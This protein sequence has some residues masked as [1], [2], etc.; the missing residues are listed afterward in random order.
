MFLSLGRPAMAALMLLFASTSVAA[1]TPLLAA[2]MF[3]CTASHSGSCKTTG[4]PVRLMNAEQPVVAHVTWKYRTGN[5][6]RSSPVV[7]NDVLFVGS[8]NGTFHAIDA[9]TGKAK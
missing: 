1:P 4:L 2:E 8:N 5:L 9:R 7:V 6:N 3:R